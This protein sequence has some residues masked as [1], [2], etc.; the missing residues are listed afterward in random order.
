M[1]IIAERDK[2]AFYGKYLIYF[3]SEN[4]RVHITD[5]TAMYYSG[6]AYH[7][8]NDVRYNFSAKLLQGEEQVLYLVVSETRS[9]PKEQRSETSKAYQS[10]DEGQTWQPLP[11]SKITDGLIVISSISQ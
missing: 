11:A 10:Q 2:T 8:M 9:G 4:N 1:K 5:A 6:H 7:S 3:V